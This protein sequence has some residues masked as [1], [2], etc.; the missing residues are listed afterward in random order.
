[1]NRKI[2]LILI[3][4]LFFT[5]LGFQEVS[6]ACSGALSDTIILNEKECYVTGEGPQGCCEQVGFD[7]QHCSFE[8]PGE[9]DPIWAEHA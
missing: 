4:V 7:C 5:T 9:D 8:C 3:F 6:A 1:M 2:F